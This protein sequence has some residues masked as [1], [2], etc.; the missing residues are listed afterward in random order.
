MPRGCPALPCPQAPA[1]WCSRCVCAAP[2]MPAHAAV[3][4][5]STQC[6]LTSACVCGDAVCVFCREKAAKTALASHLKRVALT[7]GR[8]TRWLPAL[9]CLPTLPLSLPALDGERQCARRHERQAHLP[10]RH[11]DSQACQQLDLLLPALTR[12]LGR[13]DA[14]RAGA[15]L[16]RSNGGQRAEPLAAGNLST[17]GCIPDRARSSAAVARL[18]LAGSGSGERLCSYLPCRPH[19]QA[20]FCFGVGERGQSKRMMSWQPGAAREGPG[21]SWLCMHIDLFMRPTGCSAAQASAPGGGAPQVAQFHTCNYCAPMAA[22][23][24]A[25]VPSR[26]SSAAASQRQAL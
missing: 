4:C 13:N 17:A 12:R 11:Q 22:S 18:R 9:N 14:P 10:A 3:I 7:P 5:P 20:L 15:G 19:L 24:A 6:G 25:G 8:H 26:C 23:Y 16:V 2:R 1:S 21:A